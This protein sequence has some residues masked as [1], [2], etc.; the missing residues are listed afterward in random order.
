M[1]ILVTGAAGMLGSAVVAALRAGGHAVRAHDR[2]PPPSGAADE[3][4]TGD[5]CDPGGLDGLLAGID[6]VV[7]AAA[8]PAPVEPDVF[9][10]NV[11]SAYHLLEAAA[12]I[13]VRRIVYVSSLSAVGLAWSARGAS[14]LRLPLTEDHPYVGDDPYGLSKRVGE[15]VTATV[16]N[17]GGIPAVSLRLPFIGTGARLR[18]HLDHVAADL[19][20]HRGDLWSWLDTRD[21]VAAVA[22]ALTRPL[23]GHAVVNVAAPDTTA[24]VE[25][26]RLLA[27]Y[28]PE[29]EIAE[30]LEGYAVPVSTR[31]CRDLLGFSPVHT[32]RN[33]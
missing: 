7:H 13:G 31:L 10:N 32:W 29:A 17:R 11:G 12:A 23:A 9:A 25:T 3:A 16:S 5:L 20:G 30:A 22:A 1:K 8:I 27:E 33:P 4:V 18:H 15:L 28:H 14:P 6:A 21:A 26:A 2:T 24:T 19:G